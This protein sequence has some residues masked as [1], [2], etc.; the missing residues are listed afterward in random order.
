MKWR[1]RDESKV[2][3]DSDRRRKETFTKIDE[4]IKEKMFRRIVSIDNFNHQLINVIRR[5]GFVRDRQRRSIDSTKIRIIHQTKDRTRWKDS[6]RISTD[7]RLNEELKRRNKERRSILTG[8][9]R[10]AIWRSSS[11]EEKID[12]K[13]EW[14]ELRN[15]F[16]ELISMIDDERLFLL[17]PST[18]REKI[19]W[20]RPS[21]TNPEGRKNVSRPV[22]DKEIFCKHD[23]SEQ[24]RRIHSMSNIEGWGQVQ[25]ISEVTDKSE[26]EWTVNRSPQG[27]NRTSTEEQFNSIHK[28]ISERRNLWSFHLR[29]R[30]GTNSNRWIRWLN[31]SATYRFA[32]LSNW[33]A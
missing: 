15:E 25:R 32:Q 22:E 12:V 7:T 21:M 13:F 24:R 31:S 30:S 9:S 1:E 19:N 3:L 17:S 33:T 29:D 23:D 20:Y 27:S 5:K 10:R 6:R 2:S 16:V 18:K 11:F 28:R 8:R 4:E 26:V 14:R